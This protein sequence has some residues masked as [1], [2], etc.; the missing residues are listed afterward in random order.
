MITIAT[1][2]S[3]ISREHTPYVP[4]APEEIADEIHL[5]W[6][7]GAAIAHVHV[8]DAEGRACMDFER[9]RRVVELVRERCDVILNLSSSGLLGATDDE[10]I[11][12]LAEL[13]PEMASFDA[14]ST[15]LG[16]RVFVSHPAFLERLAGAMMAAQVKPDIEVFE[17][18]M[19][20]S[21]GRRSPGF[22]VSST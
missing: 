10:R 14:G 20:V 19:R 7:A 5:S 16:G 4:L 1:T 8:R 12:P 21:S 17:P 3:S 9:F 13:H 22:R 2:G 11:R 18:G 6:Q 15:N